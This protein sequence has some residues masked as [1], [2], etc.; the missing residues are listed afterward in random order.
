MFNLGII[1]LSWQAK[2]C[3]FEH[4]MFEFSWEAEMIKMFFFQ[5]I[6]RADKMITVR[7]GHPT[8]DGR[9]PA[10]PGMYETL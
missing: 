9:N 7:F 2:P 8:V 3:V 6:W 10:P 1:N 4:Q 5:W